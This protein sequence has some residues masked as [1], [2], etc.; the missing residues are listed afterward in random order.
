MEWQKTKCK[1]FI[2]NKNKGIR[3]LKNHEFLEHLLKFRLRGSRL[4]TKQL[5]IF[6]WL[7]SDIRSRLELSSKSGSTTN[8]ML[9]II[10]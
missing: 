7:N 5:R 3:K 2:G 10:A 9:K 6:L 8:Y 4:K 1:N